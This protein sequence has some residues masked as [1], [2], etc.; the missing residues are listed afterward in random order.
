MEFK[1][2]LKRRTI[3]KFSQKRVEKADIVAMIEAARVASCASNRQRLRYIAIVSR[4]RLPRSCPI[5]FMQ[6][7][8]NPAA[9][10]FRG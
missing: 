5:R 6:P 4:K 1:E 10:R 3:R 2:L 8:S 9:I 7:W